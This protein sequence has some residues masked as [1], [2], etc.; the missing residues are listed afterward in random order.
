[1]L[2]AAR[3]LLQTLDQRERLG[4]LE[5]QFTIPPRKQVRIF[6]HQGGQARQLDMRLPQDDSRQAP[7]G[8]LRRFRSAAF[9]KLSGDFRQLDLGSEFEL[10]IG[11]SE[12]HHHHRREAE[13]IG[14]VVDVRGAHLPLS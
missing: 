4:L 1:M 14:D 7:A 6:S 11:E 10:A 9:R 5:R 2:E 8:F 13:H 12:A 3:L